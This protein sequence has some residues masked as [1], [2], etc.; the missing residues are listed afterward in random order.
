VHSQ[1]GVPFETV[2]HKTLHAHSLRA[3]SSRTENKNTRSHARA[4]TTLA[5]PQAPVGPPRVHPGPPRHWPGGK[6]THL[7][8]EH[9]LGC[10]GGVD[11][12]GLDGDDEVAAHLEEVVCVQGNDAGL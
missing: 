12:V 2:M 10:R 8:G 6:L 9:G 4:G 3:S 1:G 5:S 11:T 7:L